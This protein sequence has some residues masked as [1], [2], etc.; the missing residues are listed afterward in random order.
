MK[1]AVVA[2][3]AEVDKALDDEGAALRAALTLG[4]EIL[5]DQK[6]SR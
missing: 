2:A 1:R 6:R 4:K 5:R 3:L